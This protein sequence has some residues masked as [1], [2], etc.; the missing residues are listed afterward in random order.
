MKATIH[1]GKY[2]TCGLCLSTVTKAVVVVDKSSLTLCL[3]CAQK[4]VY[5]IEKAIYNE[6]KRARLFT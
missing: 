1:A 5:A 2:R 4:A 3:D 6:E